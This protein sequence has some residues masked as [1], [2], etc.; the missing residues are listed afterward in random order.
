MRALFLF[1]L[2]IGLA[3]SS[4]MTARAN[5]LVPCDSRS[6]G[7]VEDLSDDSKAPSPGEVVLSYLDLP[8]LQIGWGLQ[9][10]RFDNRFVLRSVQ[11]RRDWRGG[12][13]EV[14][15]G[16]FA[17][18]PVQP[19]PLVRTVSLSASLAERLRA[20]AIAEIAHA[21]QTN[22]RMGLDGEGFYFYADGK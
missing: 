17:A 16:V 6:A 13:I 20:I 12:Y 18:N 14:R 9:L 5:G 19:D 21:D 22:A 11:F 15:P 2:V 8:G 3:L 10:I 7:F 1:A 4:V